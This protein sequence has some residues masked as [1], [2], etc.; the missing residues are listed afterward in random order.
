MTDAP[1]AEMPTPLSLR[2]REATREAHERTENALDLFGPGLTID[3]YARLLERWHGFESTWQRVAPAALGNVVP[4]EFLSPRRKLHLLRADLLACGRSAD[5]LDRL[6]VVPDDALPWNDAAGALGVLYVVEGS[7][8]GG[9]HVAKR[10]KESLHL[11]PEH[12][13]AYFSSY[14]PDVGVRWRETKRL[15]DSAPT[16]QDGVIHSA[17]AAFTFLGQWLTDS[18][19]PGGRG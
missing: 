11:T 18:P 12:G 14:G 15:L 2:L 6:P 5:S 19:S 4:A 9:Q 8:L 17:N 13:L 1:P 10:I 16:V 3:R 7:T